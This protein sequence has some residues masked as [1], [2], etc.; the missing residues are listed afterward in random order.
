VVP[1]CIGVSRRLEATLTGH[2][3]N[4]SGG[5]HFRIGV[6]RRSFKESCPEVPKK[7]L[8]LHNPTSGASHPNAKELV[9]AIRKALG[10][11]P[12]YF[13]TKNADWKDALSKRWD[14]VILAG[15]D[16]TVGKSV[17]WLHDRKTPIAILPL[18]TANNVAR[19][20]GIE[21]DLKSLLSKLPTSSA[22]SLDVGSAK[23]PWGKRMFLE[24][25]GVGSI[26]EGI[27]RS[28]PRPP[29]PIRLD[30]ARED[31]QDLVENAEPELFELNVDGEKFAGEF[32]FV[33]ILNLSYT[34]PALPLAFH[35]SPDDG[36]F[37]VVFLEAK[38]RKPMLTWLGD[39]PEDAPPPLTVL[40]G[41][42]V[43]MVWHGGHL[44]I[45]SRVFL[46]PKKPVEVTI[47]LE[48]QSFKVLVPSL[49]HTKSPPRQTGGRGN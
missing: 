32:L 45:D 27:S 18:G 4:Q 20:L 15:G 47:T 5:S 11:K 33:E 34:G 25:V 10:V 26:A 48:K 28:G 19:S 1:L 14:A 16:G 36:L 9:E 43:K 30:M 37:D 39:N 41:R 46:P 22:R 12:S 6:P 2:L 29:T 13:S 44:R 23:G 31:L 49:A 35:A 8:L 21:G 7:V 3:K 42:K 40:Q 17:R 24:A 38:N